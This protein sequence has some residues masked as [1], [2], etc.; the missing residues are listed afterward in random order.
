M[1]A[2]LLQTVHKM[3]Q[4]LDV[5]LKLIEG[6]VIAHSNKKIKRQNNKIQPNIIY[7]NVYTVESNQMMMIKSDG[8]SGTLKN[9]QFNNFIGHSNAYSLDINAYW[10]SESVQS[11]DGVNYQNITFSNWKGTCSNGASRAPINV[12]CPSGGPCTDITIEDFSMW[13]EAGSYELYKCENA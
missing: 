1:H 10:S 8:G 12:I 2:E 6:A 5:R 4:L 13:T 3:L 11:G 7:N 9:V